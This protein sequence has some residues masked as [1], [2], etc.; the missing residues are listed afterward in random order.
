MGLLD[1]AGTTAGQILSPLTNLFKTAPTYVGPDFLAGLIIEELSESSQVPIK[2]LT[3]NS[4]NMPFAPLTYGGTQHVVS[5]YYPGNAEP[6]TQVFG[7]REDVITFKGRF[8]AKHLSSDSVPSLRK[9]PDLLKDELDG[10][11]KRGN[12][13]SI[14]L[15]EWVRYGYITKT[16]FNVRTLADIDYQFEFTVISNVKPENAKFAKEVFPKLNENNLLLM[17]AMGEFELRAKRDSKN[18][19]GGFSPNLFDTINGLISTVAT[20]VSAVTQFVDNVIKTGEDAQRLANR[21]L[22]LIKNATASISQ[23]KRRV[24]AL[25]AYRDSF[26]A[27]STTTW[28][29]AKKAISARYVMETYHSPSKVSSGPALSAAQIASLQANLGKYSRSDTAKAA[30]LSRQTGKSME[31]ILLEMKSYFQT[32][33]KLEPLR[34]YRVKQGD[35][36]QTISILFYRTPNNWE[37]IYKH[38]KLTSTV[39][40]RGTVLEIPKL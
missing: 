18:P 3:L 13:V 28:N 7:S 40:T 33:A 17:K 27:N 16:T 38:N 19:P 5:E 2:T 10:I 20:A 6:A 29:E 24:G 12:M 37:D 34:R 23:F 32:L 26:N 9:I 36:L 39:L 8:K 14:T 15:G 4:T 1:A 31:Q 22:G 21:A 35:T 11:R 25:Q 30:A